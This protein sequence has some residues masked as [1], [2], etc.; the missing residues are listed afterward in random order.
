MSG[1]HCRSA[2]QSR[3]LVE[4]AERMAFADGQSPPEIATLCHMLGV[5]ERYLRNAFHRVHGI[6]P[7]RRLQMLMLSR[8]RQALMSTRGQSVNVTEIATRL[9]FSQLGRFSVEYR[10]MFGESPS[11]TLRQA[12]RDRGDRALIDRTSSQEAA[13]E[14][15]QHDLMHQYS[16]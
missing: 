12:V 3:R 7:H 15:A 8:A 10:K 2:I 6:P 9:G 1:R 16:T 5:S 4:Q 14:P 13:S 11:K